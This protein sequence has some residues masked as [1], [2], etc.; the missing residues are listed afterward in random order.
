L[1]WL[2]ISENDIGPKNFEIILR[3]FPKNTDLELL[4]IADCKIDA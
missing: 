1:K 3:I 4:N 2:D